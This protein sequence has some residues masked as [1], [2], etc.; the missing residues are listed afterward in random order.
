MLSF[1]SWFAV[2]FVALAVAAA[3]SGKTNAPPAKGK[4]GGAGIGA[5][6]TA[7]RGGSGGRPASVGGSFGEAGEGG[8]PVTPMG[9]SAGGLVT[10][11][12]AGSVGLGGNG[13][14]AGTG[15]GGQNTAGSAGFPFTW[16]CAGAAYGDGTCDCG[17][18][19][20]DPDC[21][22]DRLG[23][24][25]VCNGIGSC[26][27]AECPG[28][29]DED[30][31][32]RCE[33]VPMG[34]SCPYR[35]YEDGE[36]CDCGCG[37][38]DPDCDDEDRAAC[39][40]CSISGSCSFAECPGGI[41][42]S[43]N[44][45]CAYPPGWFCD[46]FY[47][48]NGACD[49]GCGAKDIDCP[50]LSVD[51]C[52]YCARGCSFQIDCP[53]TI[54][55]ENNAF[56]TEPPFDWRCPARFYADGTLCHCGCGT[57]DP[58]CNPAE[59]S[60]CDRCNVE[61]S[62][63]GQDCPGII[64]PDDIRNC[65]KPEAPEEWSCD[66]SAYGD[67]FEC[68]C[69]C[70]V[71]DVDCRGTTPAACDAC[72]N[73]GLCPGRVDPTDISSCL[74][75]PDGWRCAAERYADG[76]FCDCACGLMDPD[77]AENNFEYCFACPE[78]GCSRSDCRDVDPDDISACEG[79]IPAGWTCVGDYFGDS[80]C[81]CGCGA[82]DE[83]CPSLSASVCEFCDSPGSCSEACPGDIDPENNAV[84]E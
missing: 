39:D 23:T 1:R 37:I 55:E 28:R 62:C 35:E 32:V 31:T 63:S 14:V 41:D 12:A 5:A 8:V 61:G 81:D 59:A 11:G 15:V 82:Q 33:P 17:C 69:G 50:S 54:H 49:C 57:M 83:D 24:C 75:P 16:T 76:N 44:S 84:C 66:P 20:A 21:K 3:C 58:D 6:G 73:C 42:D 47:Y 43:D 51:D 64:N 78:G 72:G 74:P 46:F 9:G 4:G 52:E 19:A 80:G 67:G 68:H 2:M 34:W 13:N 48:G 45:Q 25:E 18:G 65:V 30:D 27:G 77:C 71:M 7:G 60:S 36:S 26:S 53:G 40:T 29:I 79:G 38:P 70:G 22:D 56:C 10:G